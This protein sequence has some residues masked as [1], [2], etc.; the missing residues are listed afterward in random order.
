MS[1]EIS[2]T[3]RSKN[4]MIELPK[5]GREDVPSYTPE[6]KVWRFWQVGNKICTFFP[7]G[8][9]KKYSYFENSLWKLVCSHHRFN[10]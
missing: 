9:K 2:N 6:K 1:N 10:C 8:G 5:M 4:S 7:L 3:L